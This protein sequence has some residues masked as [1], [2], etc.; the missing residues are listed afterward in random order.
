MRVVVTGQ[1]EVDSIETTRRD[2]QLADLDKP[3][4]FEEALVQLARAA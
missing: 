4:W 2:G 3:E 1:Y